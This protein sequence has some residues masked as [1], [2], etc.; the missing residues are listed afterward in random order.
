MDDAMKDRFDAGLK[1]RKEVLGDAY[2][3]ASLDKATDFTMA[4]QEFVTTYCWNDAWNR[5]GLEKKTRS[6]LNL[7]MLCA[8]NRPHE[9][10]VH[11]RGAVNNGVTKDEMKEIFLQVGV[12]CGVP[13]SLEAFKIAQEVFDEM[14][15]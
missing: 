10:R 12:Y 11:I 7:G 9:L 14:G 3:E 2:V 13:A 5:P 8:L 15:V 4:F 1:T 6:I